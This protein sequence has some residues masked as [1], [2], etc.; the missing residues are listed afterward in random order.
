[1]FLH[2]VMFRPRPGISDNDRAAMFGALQEAANE[3]PSVRRFQ[4]GARVTHGATYERLMAADFPFAA[5]IE[6]DDLAGLQ[7]YLA[8]P[9]H[10]RLGALFYQL[11]EAA[12]AYDYDTNSGPFAVR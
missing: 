7:A 5:V 12:L 1:M 4:V 10:A 6:F 2:V 9:K 11:Q 8:H 3:I